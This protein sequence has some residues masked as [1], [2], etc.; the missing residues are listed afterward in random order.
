MGPT[1]TGWSTKPRPSDAGACPDP[2]EPAGCHQYVIGRQVDVTKYIG[3]PGYEVLNV[4]DIQY[5]LSINDLFIACGACGA[6]STCPNK[7]LIASADGQLPDLNPD[8]DGGGPWVSTELCQLSKFCTV[9]TNANGTGHV[10]DCDCEAIANDCPP[11]AGPDVDMPD[12]DMPDVDMPD[13]DMPDGDMPDGDM[14]DVDM[15]DGDMPDVDMP[16][17]DIPDAYILD[18]YMP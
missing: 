4:E 8:P 18:A 10:T 14:P 11:D 12:V 1:G 15:P 6:N 7:F 2:P 16:D 3:C 13:V 9:T 17:V 5:S